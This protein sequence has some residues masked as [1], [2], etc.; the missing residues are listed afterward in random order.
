MNYQTAYRQLEPV[1]RRGNE[2]RPAAKTERLTTK[3]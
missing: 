3:L 1:A 2:K